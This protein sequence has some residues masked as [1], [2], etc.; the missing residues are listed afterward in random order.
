MSGGCTCG[1]PECMAYQFMETEC[2][3]KNFMCDIDEKYQAYF[4]ASAIFWGIENGFG[5]PYP[6]WTRCVAPSLAP[7]GTF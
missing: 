5:I 4:M 1:Y 2:L 3:E 7:E 6:H